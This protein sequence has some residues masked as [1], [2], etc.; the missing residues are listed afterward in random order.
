MQRLLLEVICRLM[1]KRNRAVIFGWPD[2]E[3]QSRSLLPA[4]RATSLDRITVLVSNP[5]EAG[6]WVKGHRTFCIAKKSLP[7]LWAFLTAKYVFFTHPCF[8]RRFPR[9]VVS[10]NMWHGSPIKKIGAMIAND[11]PIRCSHT[12]ATSPFWGEIMHRTITSP[13]GRM[14]DTGLPRNDRLFHEDST[15]ILE[16]LGIDASMRLIVWL[17]T[18]RNSSRGLPRK[19]GIDYGNAFAMPDV[20]PEQLNSF[21]SSRRA[22]MLVKP[23]PMAPQVPTPH[24]S[25]LHIVDDRWL[26][27][28]TV[29]LYELLGASH[30]LISDVSSALIDYLLLDRPI[31]H[32]FADLEAY[33]SSRGFTVEPIRDY[34][35]GS[36]VGSQ[37]ELFDALECEL[38]GLDPHATRR[39]RLRELSHTHMN[40]GASQRLL[41]EIGL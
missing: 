37:Q 2:G 25:H 13:G 29:S 22:V 36:V 33:Q 40:G 8:L 14:L 10:V 26:G 15:R 41:R 18:Y 31:I 5:D 24:L 34:F 9:R 4:L 17:P 23:H 39:R 6:P 3:D 38:A 32:A 35:A 16:R 20:D 21:L 11:E 7:G 30:L 19:D 1:P 12:L 28:R 27:D